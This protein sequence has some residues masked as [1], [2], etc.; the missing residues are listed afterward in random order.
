MLS[1]D[2]IIQNDQ[3]RLKL[4]PQQTVEIK[5]KPDPEP[6]KITTKKQKKERKKPEKFFFFNFSKL[7]KKRCQG[8]RLQ[9]CQRPSSVF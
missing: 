6:A 5:K 2:S 9:H 3:V 1:F 4:N 8:G 7:P